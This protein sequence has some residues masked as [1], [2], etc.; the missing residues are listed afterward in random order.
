MKSV[1]LMQFVKTIQTAIT[2]NLSEIA[3]FI[4]SNLCLNMKLGKSPTLIKYVIMRSNRNFVI[5]YTV[6]RFGISC[7]IS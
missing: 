4:N 7:G 3:L 1:E 6:C 2:Q 5:V